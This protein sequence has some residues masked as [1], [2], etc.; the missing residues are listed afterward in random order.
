MGEA[1]KLEAEAAARA[2]DCRRLAAAI[3]SASSRSRIES[4]PEHSADE[5]VDTGDD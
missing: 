1:L 3:S 2:G 5:G 4:V